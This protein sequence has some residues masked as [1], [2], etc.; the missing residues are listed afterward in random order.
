[1]V[2]CI[3]SGAK[4][5]NF[6]F[7][8]KGSFFFPSSGWGKICCCFIKLSPGSF[9]QTRRTQGREPICWQFWH[10]PSSSHIFFS[11]GGNNELGMEQGNIFL[12]QYQGKELLP[13]YTYTKSLSL[14][15]V[16][17]ISAEIPFHKH[18]LSPNIFIFK[19]FE[20]STCISHNC[21]LQ[22]ESSS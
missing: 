2:M 15:A 22:N 4:K 9:S 21:T 1:M 8:G 10:D 20:A 5:K 17:S 18:W 16:S 7:P 12:G 3:F 13:V 14:F 11:P 19:V 6:C